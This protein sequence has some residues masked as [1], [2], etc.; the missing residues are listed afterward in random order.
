MPHESWFD[1]DAAIRAH[2]NWFEGEDMS[3]VA[4]LAKHIN[5]YAFM[6]DIML[7]GDDSAQCSLAMHLYILQKFRKVAKPGSTFMDAGCGTGYL[8]LA[9]NLLAGDGSRAVG[10]EVDASRVALARKHLEDPT[11]LALGIELPKATVRR[12]HHGDALRPDSKA[13]RLTPGSVDAICV[14]AAARTTKELAPLAELLREGGLL[15]A[16]MFSAASVGQ[17][18]RSHSHDG[19]SLTDEGQEELARTRGTDSQEAGPHVPEK[20]LARFVLFQRATGTLPRLVELPGQPNVEVRFIALS[21][22]SGAP[23]L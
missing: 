17:P 16:P 4:E 8:L 22:L 10:L 11:S 6:E 7:N 19:S 23:Q 18:S 5:R 9:W 14:G 21:G 2:F 3:A 15:A 12:V 20:H 1:V 13:L